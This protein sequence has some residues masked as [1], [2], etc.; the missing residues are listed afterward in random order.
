MF[1]IIPGDGMKPLDPLA[2][3]LRGLPMAEPP[4]DLFAQVSGSLRRRRSP[5][6]W[7]VPA[8][9]AASMLVGLLL[10]W[11]GTT[12]PPPAIVQSAPPPESLPASPSSEIERLRADS[13]ILETWLG[14]LPGEAPRDGRSLMASAEIEDL[15]GLIDVQ[16]SATRNDAESLPLWRQRVALLEEL[17]SIRSEPLA[18]MAYAG[19]PESSPDIF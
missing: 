15:V 19:L 3:A 7:M 18:S 2:E 1:L 6:R 17:A 14:G 9:M 5:R 16:L 12:Q 11:P 13:R 8:A 4:Q 10:I